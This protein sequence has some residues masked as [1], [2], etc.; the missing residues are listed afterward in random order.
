MEE[1]RLVEK[2]THDELY[3]LNGRYRKLWDSYTET[4]DWKVGK[5]A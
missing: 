3:E 5:T 4:L 2:G 1:G